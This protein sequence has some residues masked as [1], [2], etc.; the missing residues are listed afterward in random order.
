VIGAD[1]LHSRVRRELFGDEPLR[2]AGYT[3]WRGICARGDLV[4][5]G[6]T[7]ETWGRG[8]R[9]GIVPIGH[10]PAYWFAVLTT[11]AGGRDE[12]GRAR[13]SLLRHFGDWHAPVRALIEATEETAIMRHDLFDRMPRETWSR[14]RITLIGDAAHP[15]TPNLGQGG[16]Q[17]IED[18][19]VL[20]EELDKTKP[21]AFARYEKRRLSR[22]NGFVQ[23]SR[24][25]GALA[26]LENGA[27]RTLRD[28][29]MRLTPDSVATA[30]IARELSR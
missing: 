13:E 7:S 12:P 14:G 2:Y 3:A 8:T 30:Q 1:G 17:A 6:Q 9:F 11:P 28:W 25:M 27:A 20:A 19:V 29:L 18:A 21:D 15:M 5:E 10:G 26:Q 16:C 22:A 23:A 24:R 4:Q